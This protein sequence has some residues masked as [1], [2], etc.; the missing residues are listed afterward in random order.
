MLALVVSCSSRHRLALALF[1]LTL[2]LF[3]QYF[4]VWLGASDNMATFACSTIIVLN[5]VFG[6]IGALWA[7][8]RIGVSACVVES[9][10]DA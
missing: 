8:W 1:E 5:N 7:D 3:S 6:V 9:C 10:D 2:R 4:N